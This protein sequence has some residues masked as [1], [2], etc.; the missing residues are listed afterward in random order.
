MSTEFAFTKPNESKN[1]C[2]GFSSHAS[3]SHFALR[4]FL[5]FAFKPKDYVGHVFGTIAKALLT[6]NLENEL[7]L[8][9]C[10]R[11]KFFISTNWTRVN[12]DA[13]GQFINVVLDESIARALHAAP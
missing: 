10:D 6:A 2:C 8:Q 3:F 4:A 9:V 12:L 13:G 1:A 5:R 11:C 7:L